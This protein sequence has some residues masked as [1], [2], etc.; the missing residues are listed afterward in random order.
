MFG[1]LNCRFLLPILC[2]VSDAKIKQ[3]MRIKLSQGWITKAPNSGIVPM[4]RQV[5]A[6]GLENQHGELPE[7]ELFPSFKTLKSSQ[8]SKRGLGCFR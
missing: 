1:L 2:G 4:S 3:N 6:S 8:T 5:D 7:N